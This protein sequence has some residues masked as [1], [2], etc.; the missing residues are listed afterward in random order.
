MKR[1]YMGHIDNSEEFNKSIMDFDIESFHKE[2]SDLLA[3]VKP[4][5]EIII[6]DMVDLKF[7]IRELA[8]EL[9]NLKDKNVKINVISYFN[10]ELNTF[11]TILNETIRMEQRWVSEKTKHGIEKAKEVGHFPGRPKISRKKLNEI[12]YWYD[13]KIPLREI[14]EKTT[15]S[16]GTVHKYVTI[17]EQKE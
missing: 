14:S 9:N 13:K 4:N 5:D 6:Y 16:L 10:I 8:E 11:L 7:S 3:A 1:I 2:F 15:L 17:L 12:K